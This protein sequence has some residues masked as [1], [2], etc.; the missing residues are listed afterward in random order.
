MNNKFKKISALFFVVILLFLTSCS[1]GKQNNE[2]DFVESYTAE[3]T[4]KN[5]YSDKISNLPDKDFKNKQ[6]RIA[7]D[8]SALIFSGNSESIVGKEYYLRNAAVEKKY[9]VKLTLTD[10]SG[11]P[12][13]GDRVKTE[14]LAGT[15]YCDLVILSNS[16]F[17]I[18]AASDTLENVRSV[19]YLNLDESYYFSNSLE[20]TTLGSYSYG[21]SGDFIYKPED[22]FAVFFNKKLLKQTQLPD[23]YQ[24][25]HE[26][27]WDLENFLIYA[28][29][30]FSVMRS[31]G[32]KMSGISSEETKETLINSLWAATG[33]P[34]F[35]N[36]YGSRPELV[37]NHEY[38]DAFISSVK[39]ILF[40]SSSFAS[41]TEEALDSFRNSE[42]FFFIAPL[43]ASDKITG[44]GVDWGVVP[45]PKSDINQTSYYSYL[46][47]GFLYAGFSKGTADLTFSGMITSALFCASEGLN[48]KLKVQTYLNLYLN[49]E[50]DAEMMQKIIE[51]P[52][53]DCAQ[54]FEQ[55]SSSF[56]AVTQT[57]L[58][59][60]IS[61]EGDFQTLYSQYSILLN[62]FL[63]SKI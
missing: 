8:S 49:S 36:E 30:V 15:D 45:M 31:Q 2:T 37:Y 24:L 14:A 39:N 48:Q 42:C 52:Y 17:Q 43:S 5:T 21:F 13:I 34:F 53:Y 51:T 58:F 23:I 16:T 61:S 50:K 29:E 19:P 4:E 1:S 22:C 44:Y 54:F 27:Q 10:E 59:R 56:P 41:D 20:S 38:T 9:N 12:T 32:A 6:F 57:L 18:L 28:E 35:I 60:V 62:K 46:D 55:T 63:D 33:F 7:T 47:S 3:S 11:L 25:V 26:N 40:R